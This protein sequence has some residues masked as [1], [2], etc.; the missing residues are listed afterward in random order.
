MTGSKKGFSLVE[1]MVVLVIITSLA[2]I[3]GPALSSL[4]KGQDITQ[5]GALLEQT[6]NQARQI[7]ITENR[8]IEVRFFQYDS[9]EIP[10]VDEEYRSMRIVALQDNGEAIPVSKILNL[11]KSIVINQSSELSPLISEVSRTKT[12]DGSDDPIDTLPV[13]GQP[14]E[15][16]YITFRSDGSTDLDPS[17]GES[18]KWFLTLHDNESDSTTGTA[19]DNWVTIQV[20][21]LIGTVTVHRP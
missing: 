19:P 3:S 10:G 4:A 16:K 2:V 5:A 9:P 7:A 13:I 17:G 18:G 14:A 20:E 6:M 12:Y 1:I 15:T 21:P 11:P 8:R